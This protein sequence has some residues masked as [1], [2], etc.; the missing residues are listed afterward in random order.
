MP[1]QH[2]SVMP[3][4]TIDLLNCRPG[5]VYVDGTIGGAGHARLIL[6]R[7][8]PGGL[9]IGMDQD[10]EAIEN[11]QVVLGSYAEN[12]RLFQ[13]NF[14]TLPTVL[15]QL[16]LAAVDGILLDV[17][18]S[19]HQ[20]E[21]SGRGFSFRKDEPLDMR[22]DCR[23]G[24]R[25]ADLINSMPESDLVMILRA[26][27][28]EPRASR[29]ARRIVAERDRQPIRSSKML[30]DIICRALPPKERHGRKTHPATRSFMALRIAVN[31]ELER[32]DEFLADVPRMLNPAGRICV[33]TFH[34]LEDR[35][36]KN[37]FKGFSNPCGCPKELPRC[38]CGRKPLLQIVT[39]RA[40]IP[41]AAEIAAN[42]LSR[43]AK[44][45]AAEKC[46]EQG[47]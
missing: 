40:L 2:V 45:R 7:I 30:A 17:G 27:G 10:A 15:S 44:L 8:V 19:L 42:P 5:K 34:S 25:A 11:A 31:K 29:I 3:G 1:Y 6:E 28:E 22:M 37:R 26:Y 23:S 35:I 46:G 20:L 43:S 32:L 13:G 39:R 33:L 12:L 14:V 9:L 41:S 18:L 36:V 4:E 21:K 24:V 38:I 47:C 16:N